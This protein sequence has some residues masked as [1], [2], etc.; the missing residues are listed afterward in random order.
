[1]ARENS[2]TVKLSI[3]N[4]EALSD[5]VA[6][7][8]QTIAAFAREVTGRW[9]DR[10]ALVAYG[11][12][13]TYRWTYA[14]L[15]RQSMGVARA[16]AASG[17]TKG[18]RVG[19]LMTNRPE[20]IA[21]VFGIALAGGVVAALNTFATPNELDYQL[22][23]S[24][25]DTLL[26]EPRIA[27]KD[28]A[29]VLLELEPAIRTAGAGRLVS[30]RF[31]FLRTLVAVDDAGAQAAGILEWSEFMR[32]GQQIPGAVIDKRETMLSPS[33]PAILFFSSGS[34]GQPKGIRSRSRT[35]ARR[36]AHRACRPGPSRGAD[37]WRGC[38]TRADRSVAGP[39]TTRR[40]VARG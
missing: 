34:T 3:V 24:G 33:D 40:P 22:R 26:F 21:S 20:F 30:E 19:I 38:R 36:R 9:P 4:G 15:W 5:Q 37:D 31:P 12:G 13:N 25:I 8:A 1:M 7:R 29:S 39:T 11:A 27:R 16:L 6:L 2:A 23:T 14:E 35:A 32:R 28:F 17:L 10:E 18:T